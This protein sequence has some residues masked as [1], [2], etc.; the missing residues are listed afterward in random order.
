MMLEQ[1]NS[2]SFFFTSCYQVDVGALGQFAMI[3]G[4][5][6]NL[7]LGSK[8][9]RSS[10]DN[11]LIRPMLQNAVNLAR[12]TGTQT[13]KAIQTVEKLTLCQG[14]NLSKL[15][16]EAAEAVNSTEDILAKMTE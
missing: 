16:T 15:A 2:Q 7:A 12:A 4:N 10:Q 1:P 6:A 13:V 11:D 3:I 8:I 5:V 14:G 9:A